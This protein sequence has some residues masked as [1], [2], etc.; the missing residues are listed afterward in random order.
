MAL[1]SRSCQKLLMLRVVVAVAFMMTMIQL[2]QQ[3]F[4]FTRERA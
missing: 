1:I 3:V 2:D 4:Q